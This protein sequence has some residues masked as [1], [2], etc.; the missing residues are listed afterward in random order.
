MSKNHKC[1]IYEIADELTK[2]RKTIVAC[3]VNLSLRPTAGCCRW[4][5]LMA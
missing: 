5:T 4:E 1:I 2:P 3:R